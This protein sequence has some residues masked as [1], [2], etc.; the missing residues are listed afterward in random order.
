VFNPMSAKQL[1]KGLIVMASRRLDFGDPALEAAAFRRTLGQ[2]GTGVT[3]VT[4]NHE[5][6]DYGLTSNSFASVSLDPPLVLWSI[7]K[8]SGSFAAFM[9]TTH[10]A[11]NILAK[12]QMSIS[13]RFAKSGGDKF[14]D[15]SISRGIGGAPMIDNSVAVF[16]CSTFTRYEGGDHMI[17]VGRV[18]DFVR[19]DRQALMFCQGQ[20]ATTDMTAFTSSLLLEATETG[21]R[22][23]P[24]EDRL[25]ATSLR[26]A[27]GN[28]FSKLATAR[29]EV[30]LSHA[31][32]AIANA[33]LRTPGLTGSQVA[34]RLGFGF[35]FTDYEFEK[36]ISNGFVVT[37][38][39][40]RMTLTGEGSEKILRLRERWAELEDN[41]L[42][43]FSESEI[44]LLHRMLDHLISV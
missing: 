26:L 13:N 42:S 28:L 43:S 9:E 18:E 5:G 39:S 32:A 20:Y 40:G 34:A 15:L 3:V 4:C 21:W 11:I 29:G 30:N 6:T 12:D 31:Q 44:A 23:R 22:P 8:S 41:A 19:Y 33:L 38:E 7:K 36:L 24:A 1:A 14:L 10:F 17:I 37:D 2:Y 16:Q 25:L 35:N 27:F